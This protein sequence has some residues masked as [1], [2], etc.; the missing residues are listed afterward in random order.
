MKNF[1]FWYETTGLYAKYH[2]IWMRDMTMKAI[3]QFGE[4]G[5]FFYLQPQ[6]TGIFGI[7]WPTLLSDIFFVSFSSLFWCKTVYGTVSSL[8]LTPI[9]VEDNSRD[10][11]SKK[12]T[13][14]T[15]IFMQKYV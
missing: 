3:Y 5:P 8:F 12:F 11:Q 9:L 7:F 10:F 2:I 14:Q 6:N 15:P 13:K 4:I 1:I